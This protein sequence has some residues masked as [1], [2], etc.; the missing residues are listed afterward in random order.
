MITGLDGSSTNSHGHSA[1]LN[2]LINHIGEDVG[3]AKDITSDGDVLNIVEIKK[4]GS[5]KPCF[6]S[7]IWTLYL[8]PNSAF[9]QVVMAAIIELIIPYTLPEIFLA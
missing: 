3:T 6:F 7:S 1:V 4:Q 2:N 8:L 9:R 5:I